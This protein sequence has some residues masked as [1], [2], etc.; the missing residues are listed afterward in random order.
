MAVPI[1][2]PKC[3]SLLSTKFEGGRDRVACHTDGCG[4]FYFG[5]ASI[6][7]GAVVVNDGKALLIQ[8]GLQPGRGT[9]QIPGG[10]VEADEVI[11]TAVEREVLE[12]AGIVARVTDSLGWRHTASVNDRPANIYVVFRLDHVSGDPIHDGDETLNA[13]FYSLAEMAEMEGVQALSLWA[14]RL[15]LA[16]PPNAG[17]VSNHDHF[18]MRP[19][20]SLFGL[21]RD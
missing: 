12:E 8:R 5:E 6:G 2:C 18:E 14:I 20:W 15:A 13:G 1:F 7:C 19:G 10:Y 11:H 9:W 17:L 4:Y 3:G 21:N 16:H